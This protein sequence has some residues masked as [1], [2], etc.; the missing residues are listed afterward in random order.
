MQQRNGAFL[1]KVGSDI[2]EKKGVLRPE[3]DRCSPSAWKSRIW[4]WRGSRFTVSPWKL[5]TTV[6]HLFYFRS[7]SHNIWCDVGDEDKA[8]CVSRSLPHSVTLEWDGTAAICN[9]AHCFENDK[10][11]GSGTPVLAY[12]QQDAQAGF[13]CK[14]ARSGISCTVSHPGQGHGKGFLINSAG[15]TLV[16]P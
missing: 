13:L 11:F 12:G 1:S 15:V 8:F 9:G 5:S 3:D 4:H 6:R 7:P 10:V 14:S 16:G 2:R